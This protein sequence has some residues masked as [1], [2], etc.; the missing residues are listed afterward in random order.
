[1]P[2]LP[3]G[4]LV[5]QVIEYEERVDLLLAAADV[6]VTRA[7]GTVAELAAMGVPSVLVPLPIATRDHQ[8]ANARVLVDAGAAV[9][10]PDDELTAPRL[11]RERDALLADRAHLEAMAAAMRGQA[12]LDAADRIA[13]L[14][15]DHARA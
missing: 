1:V 13:A 14:I 12:H 10:V 7:G 8:T 2:S 3:D 6:A 15:E 9:M 4:G 5:Y 11:A